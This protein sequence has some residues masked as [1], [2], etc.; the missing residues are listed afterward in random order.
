MGGM[1]PI[2]WV[3]VLVVVLLIFGNHL[4]VQKLELADQLYID[5]CF[6]ILKI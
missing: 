6:L 2:H 3:I 4:I 5:L 1:S